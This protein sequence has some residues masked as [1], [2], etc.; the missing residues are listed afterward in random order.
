[1][2]SAALQCAARRSRRLSKSTRRPYQFNGERFLTA[3]QENSKNSISSKKP[4]DDCWSAL[5]I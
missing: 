2:K 4:D 5:K 3:M 1:L